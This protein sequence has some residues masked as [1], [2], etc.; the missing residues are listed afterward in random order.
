MRN[1]KCVEIFFLRMRTAGE[2]GEVDMDMDV[3][4]DSV[5]KQ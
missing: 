2:S 3:E 1:T 5:Q 4:V